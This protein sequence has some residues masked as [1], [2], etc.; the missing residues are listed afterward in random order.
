MLSEDEIE[1]LFDKFNIPLLGRNRIRWIRENAPVRRV[2]G[3]GVSQTIR[4]CGRK[5]NFVIEAEALR[6]EFATI[7]SFDHSQDILEFYHQPCRLNIIWDKANGRRVA[8][9]ITPDLFCISQSG[10]YFVECK[11]D[12]HLFELNEK[13]PVR[14]ILSD[15]GKWRSPPAEL[16]AREFGC[17]F[18]IRPSSENNW[19]LIENLELLKDY[20]IHPFES[21]DAELQKLRE[22]FSLNPWGSIHEL[23]KIVDA[24][25]VYNSI[26]TKEFIFDLNN[27]HLKE[28]E[29]AYLFRDEISAQAFKIYIESK[30]ISPSLPAGIELRPGCMFIWD[31]RSWEVVNVGDAGVAAR[32]VDSQESILL[33][34]TYEEMASLAKCGNIK[35][36]RQDNSGPQ[37]DLM[38]Q[39]SPKDIQS[40]LYRH[41]ILFGTPGKKNPY[42]NKST[43]AKF[44]W[45]AQWRNAEIKYGYGFIGLMPNRDKT[46]GNHNRKIEEAIIYII[47]KLYPDCWAN[48]KQK[49]ITHFLGAVDNECEKLGLSKICTKT[50]RAQIKRIQTVKDVE[51]REGRKRAYQ[52]EVIQYWYIGYETPAHGTH[53]FHIAHIDHSPFDVRLIN[54]KSDSNVKTG[55]L[56]LLIDAYSRKILAWYFSFDK[57]SHRSCM[58]VLRDCVRRHGR[59]PQRIVSDGGAEFQSSYYEQLMAIYYIDKQ[60]RKVG[61]PR[62]GAIIERMFRLTRDQFANALLGNTQAERHIRQVSP[63]ANPIKLANWTLER[64]TIRLEEYFET[65][66]QNFHS[67]LGCTPNQKFLEGMRIYGARKNVLISYDK[68]FIITTMP[69]TSKGDAKI[70][71]RGVKIN[72]IFYNS[73]ALDRY[74]LINSRAPVRYDPWDGGHAYV[75]C[76]NE[77]VECFSEYYKAF[78]GM[79][80]KKIAIATECLRQKHRM[81]GKE[82]GI[83]AQRI[84]DFLS[85]VEEEEKLAMQTMHDSEVQAMNSKINQNLLVSNAEGEA[86]D[87]D[88]KV[89]KS[90]TPKILDTF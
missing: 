39:C 15:N 5:M 60:S 41:E 12:Q 81:A 86:V 31:G 45:K 26:V 74:S 77:W 52:S 69:T 24:D 72:Y 25:V 11:T 22:F 23:I 42:I 14:F 78:K 4:Y 18:I 17:D 36:V 87:V 10:F 83:T 58:M 49:S 80:A 2:Y 76:N 7:V 1:Q 66:H 19:V 63:E 32:C 50:L 89:N 28:V 29:D 13:D 30:S 16:A 75:Y 27:S 53:P 67:T 20:Y 88:N 44:Y 40:A 56:S 43:R 35:S 3:G 73:V 54:S 8:T 70:T 34:L 37:H 38:K 62:D 90:W 79:S 21:N 57:P 46:Q 47:E 61:K 65:Y 51:K 85:S 59:L 33:N 9:S 82:Y 48:A 6:T 84:A 64:L 55:T 68:N 71:N